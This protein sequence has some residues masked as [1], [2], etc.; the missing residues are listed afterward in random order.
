MLR[1]NKPVIFRKEESG[2][3]LREDQNVE[4]TE[5]N[6]ITDRS[7]RLFYYPILRY[8]A[9]STRRDIALRAIG[10]DLQNG[11]ATILIREN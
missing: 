4:G 5:T 3:K 2:I 7:V 10:D 6:L 9:R 11:H 1:V 8:R